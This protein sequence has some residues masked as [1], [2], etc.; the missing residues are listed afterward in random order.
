MCE[1]V[2]FLIHSQREGSTNNVFP[3]KFKQPNTDLLNILFRLCNNF[4]FTR[5]RRPLILIFLW[6]IFLPRLSNRSV[7]RQTA[8]RSCKL[9]NSGKTI[10]FC[11]VCHPIALPPHFCR[12]SNISCFHVVV[13]TRRVLSFASCVY[14]LRK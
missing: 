4:Y 6:I 5:I 13:T 3:L 10:L 9:F 11:I 2:A 8:G 12:L 14:R 1:L 7:E